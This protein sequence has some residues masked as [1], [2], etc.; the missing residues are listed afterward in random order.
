MCACCRRWIGY[1][2]GAGEVILVDVRLL[3]VSP[4]GADVE[5][6]MLYIRVTEHGPSKRKWSLPKSVGEPPY[7]K[8]RLPDIEY[9]VVNRVYV[10]SDEPPIVAEAPEEL[11]AVVDDAFDSSDSSVGSEMS[12]FESE[13][14]EYESSLEGEAVFRRTPTPY[15]W[16]ANLPNDSEDDDDVASYRHSTGIENTGIIYIHV[17]GCV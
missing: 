5:R 15:P 10:E 16:F 3:Y 14:E 13:L 1:R 12:D 6:E 4:I 11:T 8:F 7:K 17:K 9:I 2:V